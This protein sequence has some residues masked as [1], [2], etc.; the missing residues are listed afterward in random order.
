MSEDPAAEPLSKPPE[1]ALALRPLPQISLGRALVFPF[2]R[3][4]WPLAL[5]YIGAIQFIPILGF[6]IIRGWRFDIARRVGWERD[7]ALPDWRHAWDHLKQGTLLFLVTQLHYLPMYLLL[8]WPRSGV[9]WGVI[10]F[11][12][13]LYEYY[14]TRLDPGPFSAVA[15]PALRSLALLVAILIIIPPIVSAIVESA[16]QRYAQ[17]GRPGVLLEVWRNIRLACSDLGDVIRIELSILL[18]A[19]AV[20]VLS[21]LLWLTVG[22]AALIPPVMIPV[23]MWTRG[24]LMGQWILKNRVEEQRAGEHGHE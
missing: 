20:L 15:E 14:F 12:R 22:G 1:R 17:T 2:S 5:A 11:F 4:N 9:I 19:A 24:A 8:M 3:R 23:Y 21:L 6:L 13:W 16:T 7:D 18:L 10:D